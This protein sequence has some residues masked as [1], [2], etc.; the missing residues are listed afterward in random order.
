MGLPHKKCKSFQNL[1]F[2]EFIT[3]VIYMRSLI[4]TY[5]RVRALKLTRFKGPN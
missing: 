4:Y 2:V 3:I 5:M 1:H